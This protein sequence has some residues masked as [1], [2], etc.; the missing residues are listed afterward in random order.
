MHMT[1][2]VFPSAPD[3]EYYFLKPLAPEVTAYTNKPVLLSCLCAEDAETVWT[4]EG[5]EIDEEDDHYQVTVTEGE[6]ILEILSP[7]T[8]DTG[9][10][11][12]RIVKFGKEGESETECL[13][14]VLGILIILSLTL[15]DYPF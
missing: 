15:I 6:N 10:Y 1:D 2:L 8:T 7:M 5:E 3:P 12:C 9:R 14:N 4:R 11:T 13:L